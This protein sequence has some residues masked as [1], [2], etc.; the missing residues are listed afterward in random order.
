MEAVRREQLSPDA[1]D[2]VAAEQFAP[3]RSRLIIWGLLAGLVALGA[4]LLVTM[5]LASGFDLVGKKVATT[6]YPDDP[7]AARPKGETKASPKKAPPA[8]DDDSDTV[9]F[10]PPGL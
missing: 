2:A 5:M 10:I 9:K 4:V 1:E 6:V 7:G 8:N 3:S